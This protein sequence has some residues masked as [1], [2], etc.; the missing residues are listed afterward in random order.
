[1]RFI[2]HLRELSEET[3]GE[4]EKRRRGTLAFERRHTCEEGVPLEW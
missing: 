2:V 4:E 3:R 1:V